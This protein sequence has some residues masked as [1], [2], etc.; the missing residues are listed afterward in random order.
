MRGE[1]Y[2]SERPGARGGRRVFTASL[3]GQ[4]VRLATEAGVFSRARVDRGTGLLVR[5][6]EVGP[7]DRVLDLGCGYGVVGI[8]AARLAPEGRVVMVDVNERAV[9]LARENLR[10]NGI[11]NAEVRQG[12]GFAAVAG[13]RFDVIALNPPVRAGNA[14]VHRLVEQARDHLMGKGSFY[15]VGRTQQ[16]VVRLAAKMAEIY[17]QVEEV[18]KGGGYRVYR[19]RPGERGGRGP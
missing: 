8:V 14:V 17:G 15:V 16:G 10:A 5:H 3:R 19:A 2:F 1:H 11:E 4:E 9:G 13:E 6:L 18:A 7:G 12:D